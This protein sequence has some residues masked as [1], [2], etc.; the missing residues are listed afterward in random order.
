[1]IVADTNLFVY[2]YITGQRTKEAEAMLRKDPEWAAPLLWRSEFRNTL[3]G[4]ERNQEIRL[5]DVI[6]IVA[7]A[8]LW[9]AGREIYR[10]IPAS[11]ATRK[12]IGVFHL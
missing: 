6:R 12:R 8:E 2:S 1:M 3:I 4:L 10:I 5:D 11:T 9:M 7:E